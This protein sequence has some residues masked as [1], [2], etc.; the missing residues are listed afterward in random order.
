MKRRLLNFFVIATFLSLF[1][2]SCKN[3]T[4]WVDESIETAAYQLDMMAK[5][6]S[7][8]E[9][10]PR[11]IRDGEIRL[12]DLYDWTSGFF[13]GSLWYM[14]EFTKD[15]MFKKQAVEY[16]DLLYNLKDYAGTHDLGFM[17]YCSYGNGFR[18]TGD[19]SYIHVMVETSDNLI[20]RFNEKTGTIRSWDFGEWQFPVIIDN[21]MNL[22]LLFW[23][24]DF[25]KNTVYRD[26]ALRHADTTMKNH[27][28]PDFSSYHVIDYD[29]ITGNVI[30]KQTFQG[31][32]D[33]SAW[34]RGQAWGLYGYT[35]CYR[36]TGDEKYLRMAENIAG[37]IMD[38]VKTED[39]IPYWDYNAPDIPNAP[40]DASAAAVT[41]SA[42]FELSQ[43]TKQGDKYFNYAET[44]LKNLS[45]EQ[46]LAK[47]GE[48]KGFI[49]M[50]SVGHL[51]ANS[52]IDTPLNY[53]DYYYLESLMRYKNLISKK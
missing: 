29:T 46:Y 42:L 27:Y 47:K 40:R 33:E 14:Y 16:T 28:R 30:A 31:Y 2:S 34:A 6:I 8:K 50:H 5:E 15:E 43:Y 17:V 35:V 32:A 44:V 9:K 45:G 36:A 13:P 1:F 22:E 19:T 24:S 52:E 53:A 18:L 25:T 4:F 10:L 49:L 38:N 39:L 12:E 26:V 21:M 20:S 48:N 41:A 23:A 51:P 7:G 11:S 37:F 3:N